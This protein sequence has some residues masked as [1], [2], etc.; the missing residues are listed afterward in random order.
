ME[1][2]IIDDERDGGQLGIVAMMTSHM[3]HCNDAQ[4]RDHA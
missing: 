2:I 3:H 4:S 1:F